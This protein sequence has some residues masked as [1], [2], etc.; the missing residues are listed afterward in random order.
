MDKIKDIEAA[1]RCARTIASDI[2]Q[3]NVEKV[4]EGIAND[5]LFEVLKDEI[6]EGREYYKSRVEP[7]IFEKHNFYDRAIV[8]VLIKAK[9]SVKSKIW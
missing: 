9:A 3:Y 5:T 8:D 4:N 6:E 7:G 2:C 1:R